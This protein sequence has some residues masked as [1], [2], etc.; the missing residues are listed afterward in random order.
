MMQTDDTYMRRTHSMG[1][2]F[3]FVL[4]L[5]RCCLLVGWFVLLLVVFSFLSVFV[6]LFVS[7]FHLH[8]LSS[9][10]VP[11]VVVLFGLLG[12]CLFLLFVLFV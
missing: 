3:T 9:F 1:K 12:F 7:C 8:A 11:L 10:S 4:L 2:A 6:C 5:L